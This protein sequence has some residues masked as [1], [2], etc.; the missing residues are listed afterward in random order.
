MVSIVPA[1]LDAFIRADNSRTIARVGRRQVLTGPTDV[2]ERDTGGPEGND[3]RRGEMA[4]PSILTSPRF[5]LRL[6]SKSASRRQAAGGGHTPAPLLVVHL[7]QPARQAHPTQRISTCAFAADSSR[8]RWLRHGKRN[9]IGR[10]T[11]VSLRQVQTLVHCHSCYQKER[12]AAPFPCADQWQL[13]KQIT[14]VTRWRMAAWVP[15]SKRLSQRSRPRAPFLFQA[16]PSY[17]I[18][19]LRSLLGKGCP[20]CLMSALILSV[21]ACGRQSFRF[22]TRHDRRKPSTSLML[23]GLDTPG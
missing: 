23:T 1:Y 7:A 11:Y 21:S 22:V 14:Q 19:S 9:Q 10:S 12:S 15:L 8:C 4:R 20:Q 6:S 5:D 18:G 16:R 13:S 2:G 3:V 17:W